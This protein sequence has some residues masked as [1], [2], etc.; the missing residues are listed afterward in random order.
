MTHIFTYYSII[1]AKLTSLMDFFNQFVEEMN[2]LHDEGIE[3]NGQIIAVTIRAFVCDT[4][5]R[6]FVKGNL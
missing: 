5:A 4:P 6:A 2:A 1:A 3:I